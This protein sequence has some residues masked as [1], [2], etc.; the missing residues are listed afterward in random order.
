MLNDKKTFT[1]VMVFLFIFCI[2][3]VS[4]VSAADAPSASF[5]SNVTGG[6][7]SLSVQFNDTSTGSPSSWYWNFGDGS[8]STQQNPVHSYTSA[9]NYTVSLTAGNEYGNSTTS[10]YIQAYDS[11][12]AANRFN[13]SGFET[14]NLS[15]WKYGNTTTL[16]S[17]K[18][19]SGNYSVHFSN[20]GSQSANYVQQNV[21]LTTV[22]SISFWG[23]GDG[24]PVK[25]FYVYIDGVLVGT[26]NAVLNTWTEYTVSTSTYTGIHNITISGAGGFNSYI[27]DFSVNYLKNLA[28][29]TNTTMINSTKPLTV[30]FNDTSSGQVTS[31]LWSFGDGTTS[32]EKNP[33]HTYTKSGMYTVTLTVTGPYGS[34][35][36]TITDLVNVVQPTNTRT[37]KTYDSIQAA[38]DD[39]KDGDTISI[40]STSYLETYTENINVTK[41]VNIIANGNVVITALD[42]N[43]PVFS[44]LSGGNNSLIKGF[45]ITGATGSSGIYIA[46]SV[47]ATITDNIITG[48]K[49]GINV[50]NGTATVKFNAIYSNTLYGLMFTGNGLDAENNWW[51]TNSPTYVNSTTAPGKTDIYEAQSGNHAVYNP[52]IILKATS[53]DDLLKKGDKSTITVDMTHNSNGQDTSSQGTIPDLPVDFSYSLG[54]LSTTSTTVSKGNASTVITGGSTSG[55][56]NVSVTVTGCTVG[57]P[58]TVDTVAPTV[59]ATSGGTFTTTKTVTL[60]TDDSTATIYYTEDGTDPRTSSSKIKYTKAL[61]I[62]K[63]T[64]LRYAAVDPAGNW[65]VLYLQ[66]Y[67]IGTGGL[68]NSSYPEY[69]INNSHTGQSNYT[70]PQTNATKWTYNGVTVYGSAAI[71]SDGTIYIGGYD[72]KLYAF[73]SNGAL[74]W[75]YTTSSAILG[76]PTI[77]TDGTIFVSCWMNS[78]LYAV[79]PD[80]TLQWKYNMGRYNFGSSPVIGA[81]GTIYIPITNGTVGTLYAL[82]YNGT[83]KW[84]YSTG[85][86]QGSSAAICSDGT[87][88]IADYNGILYAIN[89][90]G[91]L[92]WNCTIGTAYYDT[93]S[94]GSN[95][96]IYIGCK[97]GA[98][99]AVNDNGTVQWKYSTYEELYGAPAVSSDGIIYVV[100]A[101]KLYAINATG[102]L[103]WTYS[104]GEAATNEAISAAIGS[105]G[106]IYVGSSTGLYALNSNGSLKWSYAA[107]SICASPV[108][109]SDGTLYIGTINGTLYAFKNIGASFTTKTSGK[110][111][112]FTDKSTGSPTSWLWSFGDGTTSTEQNPTH[113]YAKDGNYT[114][115]LTV[116]SINGTDKYIQIC[117]IDNKAPTASA[118][119][120]SGTYN[121]SLTIKLSMNESG[122]IY[123]TLNGATPTTSSKK[124]TGTFTITST[125]TLKFIAV[126][127][128][129]NKSSVYTVK[130]TIDKTAPKVSAVSPKSSATGVSRTKTVSIRL[131]ENVL[132]S[133]NWS[134][135]YIKNLKTGA[136]CKATIKISG[137][138]IY[139]TTSKKAALTWYQI[140]IPASAIKDA[141]GNNLAKSYTLK[142]KTG[143]S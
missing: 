49:I 77:G 39:A 2:T 11:A 65:S 64:T 127:A 41:R 92:K 81:D 16:S 36:K 30:Q 44:I 117:T 88:Y 58:V 142:F 99:Y 7:A 21:D 111:I 45:T 128:A 94:I 80:G 56:D 35:T 100:S 63:T 134:K 78:T 61:T 57:I 116:T 139:I 59:N 114:V 109:G 5:T 130:Y 38:I 43:S 74:K 50:E 101:S 24:T 113:T 83:L 87:I 104:I 13:N 34:S 135:V 23:Y 14:G 53:S 26:F 86:I 37:G 131:S 82:C 122:T 73:S 54:T 91:T 51:G 126:D 123:Y 8:N 119:Y 3:A 46:P 112:K 96:T 40:G 141:A 9:G 32:T 70:G 69:G 136:K 6:S 110:T 95:G 31:W 106:T 72:G 22:D 1:L 48:N 98:L 68:A 71:G 29:F 107:G 18:S 76:S 27:D 140:Y 20:T 25:Q 85:S 132:K 102:G 120:K 15:G 105:D 55:T 84:T 90:D 93:P 60:T 47:N 12:D 97:N 137:N 33:T 17:S 66:N 125:H 118:N 67:V 79:N 62:S 103:L 115:T 52:W 42:V 28:N 129:G 138:H 19:H 108:I 10:S 121:K 143:K 124:Y 4:D 89:P 133:V 75:T